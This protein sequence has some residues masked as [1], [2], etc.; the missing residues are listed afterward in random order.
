MGFADRFAGAFWVFSRKSSLSTQS[1][2]KA[3]LAEWAEKFV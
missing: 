1:P 2:R 3:G